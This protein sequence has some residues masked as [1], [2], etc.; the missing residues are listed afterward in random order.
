MLRRHSMYVLN[1]GGVILNMENMGEIDL[2]YV[3]ENHN[4]KFKRGK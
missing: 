4:L 1:H 2:P 3:Y